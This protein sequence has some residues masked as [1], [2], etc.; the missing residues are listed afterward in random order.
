M[1]A[2]F[3]LESLKRRRPLG[4]RGCRWEDNIKMDLREI[5]LGGVDYFTKSIHTQ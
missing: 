3:W 2:K 4:R 5:G 1:H